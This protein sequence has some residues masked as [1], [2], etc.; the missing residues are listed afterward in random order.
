[1]YVA[2]SLESL[3]ALLLALEQYSEAEQLYRR[4]L[5][6]REQKSSGADIA[7]AVGLYNLGIVLRMQERYADAESYQR[8]SLDMLDAL[9]DE[10]HPQKLVPLAELAQ[11]AMERGDFEEARMHAEHAVSIVESVAVSP[12]TFAGVH[13]TLA[14]ALWPNPAERRR[15]RVLATWALDRYVY[16]GAGMEEAIAEVAEWLATHEDP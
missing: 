2:N 11:L 5:R 7:V 16:V 13:Y 4:V 3:A 1:M 12:V 10:D 14:L 8:R 9:F 15:A 6:I